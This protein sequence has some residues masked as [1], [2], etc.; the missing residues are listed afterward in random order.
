MGFQYNGKLRAPEVLLRSGPDARAE[1]IRERESVHCLFDNTRIPDDL[2]PVRNDVAVPFAYKGRAPAPS[3][4]TNTFTALAE[5]LQ[6]KVPASLRPRLQADGGH[7]F[8]L[9]ALPV[10]AAVALLGIA[11][12]G[13]V[14]NRRR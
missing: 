11:A 12:V 2:L 10:V 13:W 8:P 1:L 3:E 7:K 14:S 4:A 6:A 9:L 5:G